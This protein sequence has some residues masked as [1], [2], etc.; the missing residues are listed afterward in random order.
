[1]CSFAY[2]IEA[3]SCFRRNRR[4]SLRHLRI[5]TVPVANTD[6]VVDMLHR[7]QVLARV[8]YDA[9]RSSVLA[10]E[11]LLSIWTSAVTH[12]YRHLARRHCPAALQS[13]HRLFQQ[14]QLHPLPQEASPNHVLHLFHH[15]TIHPVHHD[16]NDHF[17]HRLL[18]QRTGTVLSLQFRLLRTNHHNQYRRRTVLH[19]QT[20]LPGDKPRAGGAVHQS[21]GQRLPV[22]TNRLSDERPL[23][24]DQFCG[25]HFLLFLHRH[26]AHHDRHLHPV[27]VISVRHSVEYVRPE[28]ILRLHLASRRWPAGGGHNYGQIG[29]PLLPL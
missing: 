17:E 13:N 7:R 3:L 16:Q 1:M 24:R 27:G 10:R 8:G 20:S 2:S 18:H 11:L 19:L 25:K 6:R 12:G 28:D 5:V 15:A 29:V 9:N 21:H 22:A 14:S 26:V 4:V 23:V